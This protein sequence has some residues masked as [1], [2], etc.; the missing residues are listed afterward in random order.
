MFSTCHSPEKHVL[1]H[2]I[3]R[4]QG[5]GRTGIG[6]VCGDAGAA[7]ELFVYGHRGV[8]IVDSVLV[9]VRKDDP[10]H[11]SDGRIADHL[12]GPPPVGKVLAESLG[13]DEQCRISEQEE[14]VVDR[15]VLWST[16][17]LTVNLI[18]VLDVP[19]KSTQDGFDE[20]SLGVLLADVPRTESRGTLGNFTQSCL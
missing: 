16:S 1:T 3:L 17:I 10:P 13:L 2:L 12:T 19:P 6:E 9:A 7:E 15:P 4:Q 18:K 14:C 5:Q 11:A 20:G 8:G